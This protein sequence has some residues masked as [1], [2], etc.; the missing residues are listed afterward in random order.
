MTKISIIGGGWVGENVG[1]G[2]LELDNEVVFYDKAEER[3]K[4]LNQDGL[5]ATSDLDEA[6]EKT[7]ISF[8]C[9][10]TPTRNGK[11]ELEHIRSATK[12]LSNSLKNSEDYHLI[13]V[14][15][16]V[17]PGTTEKEVIPVLKE[18]SGKELGEEL[19]VCMNP[20]FMT[21]ISGSWSEDEKHE[22]NFFS[23][24]RIVIGE[25]DEKSGEK[26]EKIYEPLGSPIFRVDLKTAEMIKYAANC[27]LASKISYWNEI[28][29]I[30]NRLEI[31]S[32]EV[33]EIV[34]LDPRIGEYGTVHGKAFGGKCLPKDLQA[35]ID[36]SK[37]SL[38]YDPPMLEAIHQINRFMAEEHGIRE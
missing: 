6:V 34:S 37:D 26:L 32:D 22:R 15:S 19:G 4:E 10:P 36:F 9:V 33:A 2:L 31:D 24:D 1:R 28:F 30:C 35:L 8:L 13:V 17:V 3:V 20:E 11:I 14:K 5:N 7:E 18:E 23:E 29:R 38:N 12:E 27:A 21:E 16:T 25:S